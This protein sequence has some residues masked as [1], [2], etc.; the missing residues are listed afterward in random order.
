MLAAGS[1]LGVWECW[2]EVLGGA[3]SEGDGTRVL[4]EDCG[5]CTMRCRGGRT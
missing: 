3:C 5:G 1:V 2:G 4:G